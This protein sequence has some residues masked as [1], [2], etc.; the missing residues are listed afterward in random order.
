[1]DPETDEAK[2][3]LRRMMR[4][5]RAGIADRPARS[6]ALCAQLLAHPAVLGASRVLAFA[7]VGTEPDT[8]ELLRG[9]RER[10]VAVAVPEDEGIEPTW[11]DVIVVPGLAFTHDGRRLGQGGGWYDRFLPGRRDDCV[12]IGAAFE[13]QLVDDLPTDDHDVVLDVIVTA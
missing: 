9:L 11:P 3:A 8:T 4:E 12:T 6:A 13:A 1:M 10:G 5:R 2:R 7:T